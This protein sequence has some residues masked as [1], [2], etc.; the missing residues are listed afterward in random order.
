MTDNPVNPQLEKDLERYLK[1]YSQDPK[2]RVFVPLGETYRKMGKLDEAIGILEEGLKAHPNY[3]SAHLTLGKCYADKNENLKAVEEFKSTIKFAPDNIMAYKLMSYEYK[4]LGD[5]NSLTDT[6]QRLVTI[7]PTDEDAIDFLS[8]KGLMKK[9]EPPVE[10]TTYDIPLGENRSQPVPPVEKKQPAV[11]DQPQDIHAP[12]SLEFY[13]MT[14][15]EIYLKQGLKKEAL[16]IYEVLSKNNPSNSIYS[17]ALARLKAEQKPVEKIASPGTSIAEQQKVQPSKAPQQLKRLK[18]E[19]KV[20]K[21]NN[22]L[23]TIGLRKRKA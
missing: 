2:S 17:D 12:K 14:L 19:T 20:T 7:S 18:E 10:P 5:E 9:P 13:T 21:L 16:E 11:S 3:A 4:K 23:K 22:L 1:S 15:A 6:Y 8:S